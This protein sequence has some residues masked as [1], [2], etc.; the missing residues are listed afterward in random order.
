M[1]AENKDSSMHDANFF[2]LK[3]FTFDQKETCKIS[4]LT[5]NYKILRFL[6]FNETILIFIVA[7]YLLS[8][9]LIEITNGKNYFQ[10]GIE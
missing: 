1:V 5:E 6:I 8:F 4:L 10:R 7:L 3:A 2:K 9:Y